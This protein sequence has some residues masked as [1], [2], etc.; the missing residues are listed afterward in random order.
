MRHNCGS[1]TAAPR[2]SWAS[3]CTSGKVSARLARAERRRQDHDRADPH[4][5]HPAGRGPGDDR[6]VRRRPRTDQGARR[7]QPDRAVRRRRRQ[8]DRPG[9]PGDGRPADAPR[10]DRGPPPRPRPARPPRSHRRDRPSGQDVLRRHAPAARSR[11]EPD[12]A[13]PGDLRRR[14]DHRPR[15]GEPADPVGRDRRTRP[16]RHDDPAHHAVPRGGGPTRRSDRA[17]GPGQDHCGR[18]C[19]RAEGAHRRRADRTVLHRHSR[20]G[21]RRPRCSA[22]W[23]TVSW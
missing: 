2:C 6:R 11:D 17:A 5:A 22:A 21:S 18:Y 1:R 10:P 4:H 3:T 16:G 23:P 13:A 9:E 14:A 12:R 19:G 7:D 15:P 20:R 8:P